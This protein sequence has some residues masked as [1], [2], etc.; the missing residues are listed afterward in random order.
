MPRI[1]PERHGALTLPSK[2]A[3]ILVLIV[4]LSTPLLRPAFAGHRSAWLLFTIV[5]AAIA[6][7]FTAAMKWVEARMAA[8][9][10]D[11]TGTH[12]IARATIGLIICC[13]LMP[14]L[15]HYAAL[16]SDA[17][18]VFVT[19]LSLVAIWFATRSWRSLFSSMAQKLG[20]NAQTCYSI[21]GLILALGLSLR[22]VLNRQHEVFAMLICSL[23]AF[24]CRPESLPLSRKSSD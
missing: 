9:K 18:F 6:A 22:F 10:G 5:I 23:A 3:R 11:A 7:A 16:P 13:L 19:I 17:I 20:W 8:F 12:P 21:A 1:L 14:V 2:A 15:Y 24:G 4:I